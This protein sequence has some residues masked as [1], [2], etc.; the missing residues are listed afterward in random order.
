MRNLRIRSVMRIWKMFY[1]TAAWEKGFI[2]KMYEE[3]LTQEEMLERC[4]EVYWSEERAKEQTLSAF[5]ENMK[6]TL[7]VYNPEN[8]KV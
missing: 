7:R 1:R 4:R 5:Y 3:G 8:R 6:G 2:E